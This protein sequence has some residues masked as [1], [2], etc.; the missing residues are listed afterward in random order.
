[1]RAFDA[2]VWL[3]Q[4]ASIVAL[5]YPTTI[6]Y[7][8]VFPQNRTYNSKMAMPVVFAVQNAEAAFKFGYT[9]TWYVTRGSNG[10]ILRADDSP[11]PSTVTS[12]IYYEYGNFTYFR[13]E[14]PLPAG[15]YNMST[16]LITGSCT[17]TPTTVSIGV[18]VLEGSVAFTVVDDGSGEDVDLTSECPIYQDSMTVERVT[19]IVQSSASCPVVAKVEPEGLPN[20]CRAKISDD[21]AK[22]IL[23]DLTGNS[24]L[25]TCDASAPAQALDSGNATSASSSGTVDPTASSSAG[26]TGSSTSSSATPSGAGGSSNSSGGSRTYS[27]LIGAAV[28]NALILF[29]Y[30][31]VL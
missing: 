24:N 21:A 20:P 15:T 12:N 22:C 27:S 25:T 6:E 26:S 28:P 31:W 11:V 5:D 19:G 16:R 13:E 10:Q 30:L 2:V 4:A 1:M 18:T 23:S 17:D 9:L 8:L 7:D 3:A 14:E 29:L